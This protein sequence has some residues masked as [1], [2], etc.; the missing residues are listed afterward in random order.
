MILQSDL[1]PN[2][3]IEA[4]QTLLQYIS[5]NSEEEFIKMAPNEIFKIVKSRVVVSQKNFEEKVE[6]FSDED[7]NYSQPSL[8]KK[9]KKPKI[10]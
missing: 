3:K 10:K 1:T 4:M 8:V 5:D 6:D 7:L 9:K 2:S